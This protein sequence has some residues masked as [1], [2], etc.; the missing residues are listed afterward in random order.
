MTFWILLSGAIV[1][2]FVVIGY[3]LDA[4][5]ERRPTGVSAADWQRVSEERERERLTRVMGLK[6]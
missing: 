4:W 5:A 2:A 6:R 1:L 3:G